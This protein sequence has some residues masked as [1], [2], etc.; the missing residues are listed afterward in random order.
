M[1]SR[2]NPATESSAVDG[3]GGA[4]GSDHSLRVGISFGLTSGV[5]T[6]L[7]L[8]VGLSAG[9]S[10]R[11]AVL[12]GIFTIAF[13]DSLSDAL[14]IHISEESEGV[15]SHR[16]VWKS[17]VATFLAKLMTAATFTVPIM[18][19]DLSAASIVAI[20]W[21]ACVL[22]VLSIDIA[23][24]QGTDP[25]PLVGEHLGVAALVVVGAHLVGV[26]VAAFFS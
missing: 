2:T 4:I 25:G 5:I 15:H 3:Q 7:G 6:T 14:G 19:F 1:T 21:G 20:V 12:G 23:R 17:T 13:A 22:T 8:L 10:S 11:V 9:T 18:L 16:E 24:R 26:A